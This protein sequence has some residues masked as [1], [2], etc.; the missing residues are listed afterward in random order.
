MA[1]LNEAR[2]ILNQHAANDYEGHKH[3]ALKAI[4]DAVEELKICQKMKE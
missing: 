1:K 3:K 2:E 4:D